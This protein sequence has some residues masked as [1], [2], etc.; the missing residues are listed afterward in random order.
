MSDGRDDVTDRVA[1]RFGEDDDTEEPS[2]SQNE[3][4]E[5]KS[6]NETNANT[7]QSVMNVK[8]AWNAKT[9]YLP[10][11]LHDEMG[12]AYKRLDL[13]LDDDFD[14]LRKTRHFYPLLIAVGLERLEDM[15]SKEVIERLESVDPD[16][17]QYLSR[18]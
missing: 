5:Q 13:N 10:D 2:R 12:T 6:Q 8:N 3:T 9:V 16:L 4:N 17:A 15:E 18:S 14:E 1:S 11:E 7:S